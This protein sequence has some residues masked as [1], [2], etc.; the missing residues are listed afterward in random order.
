MRYIGVAGKEMDILEFSTFRLIGAAAGV[1]MIILAA[2]RLRRVHPNLS[3]SSLLGLGGI[4]L[5]LIS[6]FP[7]AATVLTEVLAIGQYPGS[8]LIALLIIAVTVLWIVSA[9]FASQLVKNKDQLDRLI[10]HVAIREFSQAHGQEAIPQ[11]CVLAILP[12]LNEEAN[13]GGVLH[14]MPANIEGR[15]VVSLV[16]DDGSTDRTAEIAADCGALV[17]R[18][19]FQR[20]GGAAIRL[21]FEAAERYGAAVAVNIDSDGQNDPEEMPGLVK[22]IL[23]DEADVMIGS[24]ILGS[25][26]ITFWWRHVGVKLFSAIFNVLLGKRITDIS[27][28]YRAIRADCLRVLRLSQDQYHTSEFLVMCAKL[29]FRIGETPIHFARRASGKSK[30]GNEFLYGFRFARALLTAWVRNN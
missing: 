2:I 14:K 25:H 5:L 20:G 7:A 21:G 13:I 22:P 18:S 24:R 4:L 30:K 16:V 28:G 15:P 8:R 19:P 12:A 10:R 27:S 23:A 9:S 6:L 26:E 17:I 3:F 29:G 11:G 1:V